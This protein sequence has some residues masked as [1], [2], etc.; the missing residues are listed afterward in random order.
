[1]Q[2]VKRIENLNL[3]RFRA[4]G[5]VGAGVRTRTFTV[6]YLVVDHRQITVTGSRH[7][8]TSFYR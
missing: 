2:R 4:R 1:M 5:I 7:D 6:L 3:A 8:P